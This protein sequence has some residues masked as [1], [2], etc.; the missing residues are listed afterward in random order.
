MAPAAIITVLTGDSLFLLETIIQSCHNMWKG[1]NQ[2]A[3]SKIWVAAST[4]KDAEIGIS[5]R[6]SARFYVQSNSSFINCIRGIYVPPNSIDGGMNTTIGRVYNTSFIFDNAFKPAYQGQAAFGSRPQAGMEINTMIM[7]TAENSFYNLS[8]GILANNSRLTVRDCYFEEIHP[9]PFYGNKFSHPNGAAIASIAT[10][11]PAGNLTVQHN[12]TQISILNCNKGIFTSGSS[13]FIDGVRMENVHTGI[14][15]TLCKYG[16]FTHVENCKINASKLGIYWTD[17]SGASTMRARYN[18]I[19]VNGKLGTGISINEFSNTAPAAYEIDFNSIKI[20]SMA[21]SGISAYNVNNPFISGNN[22]KLRNFTYGPMGIYVVGCHEAEVTCN[23]VNGELNTTSESSHGLFFYE[24]E[25]SQVL[26][27]AVDSTYRGVALHGWNAKSHLAA[28]SF[29]YHFEGLYLNSAAIIDTQAHR[30]NMW[31]VQNPPGGYGAVNQN[32]IPIQNLNLNKFIVDGSAGTIY[33]PLIPGFNAGW[34]DPETGTSETCNNNNAICG[35]PWILMDDGV[36]DFEKAIADAAEL[37]SDFNDETK[38]KA[39]LY[40]YRFLKNNPDILSSD[41]VF[42][43]FIELYESTV[44]SGIFEVEE[45][46]RN[47]EQYDSTFTAL[48]E[49]TDSL[50]Q[51][52]TDSISYIYEHEL[53]DQMG[54]ELESLYNDLNLMNQSL[55]NLYIQREGKSNLKF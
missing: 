14:Y 6:D 40:L 1:I 29:Y 24:N 17:N 3:N 5:S 26:C 36:Y 55:N 48:I 38:S 49:T 28:N 46:L 42:I 22:I 2:F 9:D 16:L 19:K 54:N 44:L 18:V 41:Q 47:I 39:R 23:D 33:S 20:E 43:D 31:W 10:N 45:G 27:N 12:N 32:Y 34:F 50:I 11:I 37:A 15:S 52:V 4:I 30:G 35:D 51:V 25:Y 53:Q 13:A 7:T 21:K 8:M